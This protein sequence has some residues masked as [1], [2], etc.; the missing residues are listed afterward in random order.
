[1]FKYDTTR[2]SHH[3]TTTTILVQ[4]ETENCMTFPRAIAHLLGQLDRNTDG[5]IPPYIISELVSIEVVR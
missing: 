4:T 3:T 2:T 1:M 5:T